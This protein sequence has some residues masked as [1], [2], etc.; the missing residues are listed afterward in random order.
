MMGTNMT[1]IPS[2]PRKTITVYVSI[3]Y[4]IGTRYAKS[5]V[6]SSTNHL[7]IITTHDNALSNINLPMAPSI[8][9]V[10]G[11]DG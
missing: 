7:V 3:T 1:A 9:V 10:G 8:D 5:Q 6:F 2:Q 4:L 11:C